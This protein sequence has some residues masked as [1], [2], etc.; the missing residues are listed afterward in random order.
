MTRQA[1]LP[2]AL[3]SNSGP[4]QV[5]LPA[6]W[7]KVYDRKQALDK[8]T[9]MVTLFIKSRVNKKLV[10]DHLV[11]FLDKY[12]PVFASLPSRFGTNPRAFLV[13]SI[14]GLGPKYHARPFWVEMRESLSTRALVRS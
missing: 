1:T 9:T 7:Q 4:S 8:S 5:N 6:A 12:A 3:P 11:P 2:F 14:I 10:T 13:A